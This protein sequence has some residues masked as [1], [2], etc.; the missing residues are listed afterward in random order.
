VEKVSTGNGASPFG[1]NVV[2]SLG[3]FIV[4]VITIPMGLF[5]LEDN[6]IIQNGAFA[7]LIL[8]FGEW[9]INCA[10]IGF[11]FERTPFATPHQAAVLGNIIFNYAFVT[12]VP[13]W[14]NEKRPTVSI[15]K[16]VWAATTIATVFYIVVGFLGKKK[17]RSS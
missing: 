16:S 4:L 12:T 1:S 2:L 17:W 11:T 3:Y 14:I 10:K 13:S 9:F 15:N 5:N 6:I 8:I 7:F